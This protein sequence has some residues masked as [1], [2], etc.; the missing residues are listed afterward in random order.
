MAARLRVSYCPTAGLSR[1]VVAAHMWGAHDPAR[2]K[3]SK[4]SG[5]PLYP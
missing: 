5:H 4:Y 3:V 1:R 2:M